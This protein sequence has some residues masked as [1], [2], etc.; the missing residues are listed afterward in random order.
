M[1]HKE[2]WRRSVTS[3]QLVPDGDSRTGSGRDY[4]GGDEQLLRVAIVC[5]RSVT[6][7]LM[8]NPAVTPE[9]VSWHGINESEYKLIEQILGRAPRRRIVVRENQVRCVV[10]VLLR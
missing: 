6:S 3:V 4:A 2:I 9:L 1:I 7:S 5:V 10:H 8:T